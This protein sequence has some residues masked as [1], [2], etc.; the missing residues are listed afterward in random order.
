MYG[1]YR[2]T[3]N[4][5]WFF[6]PMLQNLNKQTMFEV[7]PQELSSRRTFD[8]NILS[9]LEKK[10][11]LKLIQNMGTKKAEARSLIKNKNVS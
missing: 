9:P 3:R 4:E 7:H 1:I 10:V 8:L 2:L 5:Y 11:E 6:R